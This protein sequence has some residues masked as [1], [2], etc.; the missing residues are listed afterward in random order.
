MVRV[1]DFVK[2][3]TEDELKLI[4]ENHGIDFRLPYAGKTAKVTRIDKHPFGPAY[5]LCIDKGKWYWYN[6][7]IEKVILW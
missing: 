7:T 4:S 1:G 3:K 6:S 5:M 2:I